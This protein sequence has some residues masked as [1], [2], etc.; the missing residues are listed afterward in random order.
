[1]S[2]R[3]RPEGPRGEREANPDITKKLIEELNY[4]R[5]I[6]LTLQG[7]PEVRERKNQLKNILTE[8]ED[9]IRDINE[10][11]QEMFNFQ[12]QKEFS[13]P[14][15]LRNKNINE[16]I[17]SLDEKF[18]IVIYFATRVFLSRKITISIQT[19]F[20]KL[21]KIFPDLRIERES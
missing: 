5:A 3:K 6:L 17:D 2:F 15:S 21:Q 18:G 12:F 19:L 11:L 10:E 20:N 13:I 1:M 16:L 4:I 7:R 14:E 9:L 8:I